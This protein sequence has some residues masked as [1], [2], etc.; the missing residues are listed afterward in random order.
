MSK[1]MQETYSQ[2]V[3]HYN[4]MSCMP[5]ARS[6]RRDDNFSRLD[7]ITY[8][9]IRDWQSLADRDGQDLFK[10][11]CI[12]FDAW[13]KSLSQSEGGKAVFENW[14]Q[15]LKDLS[16]FSPFKSIASFL[17]FLAQAEEPFYFTP[18]T[19]RIVKNGN[20][21]AAAVIIKM[22]NNTKQMTST[23][24]HDLEKWNRATDEMFQEQIIDATAAIETAKKD[25]HIEIEV[26][27]LVSEE[28]LDKASAMQ[29]VLSQMIDVLEARLCEMIDKK[30]KKMA[31]Y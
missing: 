19:S 31:N 25:L 23:F 1:M 28:L 7:S 8:S 27:Y 22:G 13:K 4:R 26:P 17:Q 24:P 12:D 10:L 16:E 15:F 2:L 5:F 6:D 18:D 11:W 29:T 30:R 20:F 3:G 14:K 9:I 21:V